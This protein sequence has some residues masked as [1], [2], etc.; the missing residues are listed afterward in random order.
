MQCQI[1]GGTPYAKRWGIHN[2]HNGGGGG[3]WKRI[4]DN[5]RELDIRDLKSISSNL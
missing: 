2:T 3:Y 1:P 5:N 4:I